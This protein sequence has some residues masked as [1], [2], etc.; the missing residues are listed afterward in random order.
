MISWTSHLY[1]GDKMKKK[2][3]QAIVSINNGEATFGVYCI[4]F[5]SHPDN[6]FEIMNANELLIPYYKKSEIR[7]V[8]LAKGKNEAIGLVRNMLMEVYNKTGNFDVRTYFT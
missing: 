4:A 5:A 3:K 7:I 6:L 2:K 8:G 1:I